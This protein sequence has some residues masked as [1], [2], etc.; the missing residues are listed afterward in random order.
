[1]S[2]AD[3]KAG[4]AEV[5]ELTRTAAELAGRAGESIDAAVRVLAELSR[6]HPES[7]VPNGL[8]RAVE[9]LD[10]GRGYIDAALTAVGDLDARL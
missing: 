1:M 9:E 6:Q 3:V 2:V 5:S 4:L 8:T 7:L 10:R